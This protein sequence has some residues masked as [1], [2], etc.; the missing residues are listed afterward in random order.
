MPV[1]KLL[2]V[3]VARARMLAEIAALPAERVPLAWSIGRVL[4]EDV[5]AVRG[6]PRGGCL[7]RRGGVGGGR[8]TPGPSQP[9]DGG[10]PARGTMT[11][12]W[13]GPAVRAKPVRDEL[14][15]V[16]AALRDA[17]ADLV[18]T[19]GGASVGDHDL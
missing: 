12:A 1:M 13:G 15:A 3:D 8:A 19:V 7:S 17:D 5:G 9:C 4:A 16:I 14:D 11:G 6:P 10:P 2:P 18:V